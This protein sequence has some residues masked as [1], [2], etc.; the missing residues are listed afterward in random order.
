MKIN[1]KDFNLYG[2]K[3]YHGKNRLSIFMQMWLDA[4]EDPIFVLIG[5]S[6]WLGFNLIFDFW[7]F[8]DWSNFIVIS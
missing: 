7:L 6:S 2:G 4:N 1:K 8:L 5:Y 3:L